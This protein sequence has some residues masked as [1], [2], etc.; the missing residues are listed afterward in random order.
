LLG[1]PF[2]TRHSVGSARSDHSET[3][4]K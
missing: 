2:L 4:F 1:M 3:F